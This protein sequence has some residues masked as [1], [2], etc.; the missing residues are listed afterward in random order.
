MASEDISTNVDKS[1][2]LIDNE[3]KALGNLIIQVSKAIQIKDSES[4]Q[5]ELKQINQRLVV[6]IRKHGSNEAPTCST[7]GK[8]QECWFMESK[9]GE[10]DKRGS[11]FTFCEECDTELE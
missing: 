9:E 6:L 4:I 10:D 1:A 5:Q 8:K 7:C 11:V 2:A 3:F